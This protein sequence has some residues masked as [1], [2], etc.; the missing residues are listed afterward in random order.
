MKRYLLLVLVVTSC[1]SPK[2]IVY[3]QTNDTDNVVKTNY[4]PL[5]F[6]SN[7]ILTITVNSSDIEAVK[8]F[9]LLSSS[10]GIS[11]STVTETSTK[12]RYLVSQK[13]TINFPILGELK[14]AGLTKLEVKEI[15]KNKLDPEFVKNPSINIEIINFRIS[16]LGDVKVPGT[17]NVSNE[18]ITLVEAIALAGDLNLTGQRIIEVKRT[19]NDSV[20]TGIIDLKSNDLFKSQY[21]YLEQNDVVYVKPNKSKSQDSAFNKNNGVLVSIASIVITLI[22]VLTR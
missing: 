14:V 18:K 9:N 17:Y 20:F 15:I 10:Y 11:N 7:D 3:F 16:V 21:Y 1:V 19:I 13:G 22:A 6:K 12:H 8:P 5:K 2:D 4:Q